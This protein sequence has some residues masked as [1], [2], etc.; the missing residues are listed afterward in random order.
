MRKSTQ[1]E[2][3]GMGPSRAAANRRKRWASGVESGQHGRND[4]QRGI[5]SSVRS[6]GS[7]STSDEENVFDVSDGSESTFQTHGGGSNSNSKDPEYLNR[8]DSIPHF[9]S[10]VRLPD[11]LHLAS[12]Q[13]LHEVNVFYETWGTLD[14]DRSNV[15]L[16]THGLTANSHVADSYD[17]DEFDEGWWNRI[18]GPGLPID[19]ERYYVICS[20][21]LG[22]CEGTTGPSSINPET[23]K[24]YG[25]SFP[26]ITIKDM[27]RVQKQLL[28]VLG[29]EKISTV[30]GP[31]MGGMQALMWAKKFPEMVGNC[32]A[33]A[34]TWR[35][36]AQSIAFNEVGRRAIIGDPNF[37]DGNYYDGK[38]PSDGLATAKMIGHITYLCED[39][40]NRRFGREL[41]GNKLDFT[42]DSAFQV[43]KY[44]EQQGYTF[45]DK[46]DANSYLY[47]TRAMDYFSLCH[48]NE[49]IVRRFHRS[50]VR[51]MLISYDTD[52][53]FP[54]SQ[55]RELLYALAEARVD[56]TFAELNSPFGHD[57]YLFDGEKQ[58]E[59]IKAFLKGG[60]EKLLSL[61]IRETASS[62]E[63]ELAGKAEDSQAT[64]DAVEAAL[65]RKSQGVFR[66]SQST[67]NSINTRNDLVCVTS[68]VPEGSKVLDLGC[69]DGLLLDWLRMHKGCTPFGIDCED[70][71][72]IATAKRGIPT[73][74]H[75]LNWG[76]PMFLDDT[77]DVV[78]LSLAFM[79]IKNQEEL[80]KEMLRV[81][82]KVIVTFPNYGF[83]RTRNFLM[84][85]GKM[86]AISPRGYK[87]YNTPDIHHMTLLDFRTFVN[88]NGGVIEHED[89]L[90][91]NPDGTLKKVGFSPNMRSDRVVA[92]VARA[93]KANAQEIPSNKG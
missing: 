79:Q 24:P 47:L 10:T 75:D 84:F 88:E 15:V 73:I 6:S 1:S 44:L 9:K 38:R 89:Y 37:N 5:R 13:I 86:P 78:I 56:V 62:V 7:T 19:T 91:R 74:K 40:M 32:I 41:V 21:V 90:R 59:Y 71:A 92:L 25:M 64:E 2:H 51:M 81:G 52:W 53:L 70:D 22:G 42:M 20:N 28:E 23:G 55:M 39:S 34:T 68:L 35:T 49:A 46:S 58:G 69:E 29:I 85:K 76:L 65:S 33:V 93:P 27:V 31:S 8:L 18:V 14:D 50:P 61:G 16:V 87:W 30:I 43:E 45:D 67:R 72:V 83:W 36:S 48:S 82:K 11:D 3:R 80:F 60:K 26:V 57:S 17:N 12:G 77:F 4:R 54:T 63:K 66:L